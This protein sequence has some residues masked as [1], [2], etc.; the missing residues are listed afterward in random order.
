MPEEYKLVYLQSGVFSM[1]S[2][3]Y[4]ET[5]HPV[6]GP[7]DESRSLYV[8]QLRVAERLRETPGEFVVWD[9]GTGGAANV[10]ALLHATAPIDSSLT[11]ISFDKT[12]APL[13]F[14]LSHADSLSYL[15]GY[16]AQ[17]AT[18]L[19]EQVVDFENGKQK[20]QWR[21]VTADFPEVLAGII[22]GALPGIPRP[23]AIFFD[24][25]SAAKNPEM[26]TLELFTNL[27][28]ALDPARP[29]ALANYT[30]STMIRTALLLAG[31]HVGSGIATG[32]KEETTIAANTASL[33]ERP[34]NAKFLKR[35][36]ISDSA[37]PLHTAV[38][39]RK[40]ISADSW[41]TLLRHPQFRA[42]LQNA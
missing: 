6:V 36:Q 14:A 17:I 15:K 33:I 22:S 2:L 35:V 9:V 11:I 8:E 37:E 12:T 21:S 26:W 10:S 38:Y 34:L 1:H 4:G 40:K 31:F 28:R 19:Q 39:E 41:E 27:Y 42:C 3:D 18:L 5:N 23:H 24:P 25:Y 32:F 29:C 16:E 20:V 7:A 30:R 13:A